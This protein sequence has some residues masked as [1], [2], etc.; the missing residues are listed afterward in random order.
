MAP[1]NNISPPSNQRPPLR[2]GA[3]K[4]GSGTGTRKKWRCSFALLGQ[5]PPDAQWESHPSRA[6]TSPSPGTRSKKGAVKPRPEVRWNLEGPLAVIKEY[7]PFLCCLER[8][9]SQKPFAAPRSFAHSRVIPLCLLV[10]GERISTSKNG[11]MTTAETA[12]AKNENNPQRRGRCE[13]RSCG[14]W[15]HWF[16]ADD[17]SV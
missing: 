1:P 14:P 8:T 5:E 3:P 10:L 2:K 16:L 17:V 15:L 4:K 13:F 7:P 12:C 6:K 9:F 11:G